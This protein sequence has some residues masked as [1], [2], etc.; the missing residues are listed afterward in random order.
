M[1][2]DTSQTDQIQRHTNLRYLIRDESISDRFTLYALSSE[3]VGEDAGKYT[4]VVHL[5]EAMRLSED[6]VRLLLNR[7]RKDPRT[8]EKV[9]ERCATVLKWSDGR[10]NRL[11]APSK[12]RRSRTQ[13]RQIRRDSSTQNRQICR[14]STR[15]SYMLEYRDLECS[16]AHEGENAPQGRESTN[17]QQVTNRGG[18]SN[19]PAEIVSR[20]WIEC[21]LSEVSPSYRE[22]VNTRLRNATDEH[23]KVAARYFAADT[24]AVEKAKSR[25]ALFVHSWQRYV[26]A[27]QAGEKEGVR[28]MPYPAKK[29]A[30]PVNDWQRKRDQGPTAV[31]PSRMA[32]PVPAAVAPSRM[33]AHKAWQRDVQSYVEQIVPEKAQNI[34]LVQPSSDLESER[35][36]YAQRVYFFLTTGL[37]VGVSIKL[38]DVITRFQ[39]IE[40]EAGDEDGQD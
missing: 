21:G 16:N 3:L 28:V 31:A 39:A 6:R 13:N 19:A 34:P 8:P 4:R 11:A 14:D 26:A 40:V 20:V 35:Y 2:T 33:A 22:T 30:P 1:V 15:P 32:A 9:M 17:E 23:I 10:S 37:G 29:P 7:L 36:E 5:C 27:W 12:S 38:L 24:T 18:Q 25:E